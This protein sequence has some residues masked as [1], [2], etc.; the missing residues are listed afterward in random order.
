MVT[1]ISFIL[2]ELKLR[3]QI[4]AQSKQITSAMNI[5]YN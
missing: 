4:V 5:G 2:Y 3:V 1:S